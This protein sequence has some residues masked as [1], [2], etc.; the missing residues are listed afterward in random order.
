MELDFE[1]RD[2][3]KGKSGGRRARRR[4]E[5]EHSRLNLRRWTHPWDLRESFK[6]DLGASSSGGEDHD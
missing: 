1:G 3:E 6:H 5:A 2:L 4:R